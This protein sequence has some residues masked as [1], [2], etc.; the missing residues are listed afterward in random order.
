MERKQ[1]KE[2]IFVYNADSGLGNALIDGAH[3]ILDPSTYSCSLCQLTHGAFREREIWRKYRTAS[4]TSMI[5]LHKDEF[6]KEYASKFGHAF[7]YPIILG[8]TTSGLEVVVR[9]EELSELTD[10]NALIALLESR[11]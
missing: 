5:F 9:K 3:K 8:Q 4:S 2:L 11:S 1:L 7:T 10:A 6:K